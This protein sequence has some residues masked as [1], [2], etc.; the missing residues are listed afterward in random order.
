MQ[1]LA[2]EA[3]RVGLELYRMLRKEHVHLVIHMIQVQIVTGDEV[4]EGGGWRLGG[5][6]LVVANVTDCGCAKQ[7][8][9]VRLNFALTLTTMHTTT[10]LIGRFTRVGGRSNHNPENVVLALGQ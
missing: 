3:L 2:C 9:G 8:Q 5:R 7:E 4:G 6:E 1:R 10:T